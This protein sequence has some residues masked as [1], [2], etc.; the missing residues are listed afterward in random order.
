MHRSSLWNEPVFVCMMNAYTWWRSNATKWF[1]TVPQTR[2]V[3]SCT[4]ASAHTWLGFCQ[5]ASTKRPTHNEINEFIQ[6]FDI[7]SNL[8]C[9]TMFSPFSRFIPIFMENIVTNFQ[10]AQNVVL[11]QAVVF[12]RNFWLQAQ[13]ADMQNKSKF[14]LKLSLLTRGV[15]FQWASTIKTGRRSD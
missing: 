6:I 5:V 12:Y 4:N 1:I 13:A 2:S 7:S 3:R 14:W 8:F 10:L 15:V 9:A 11:V